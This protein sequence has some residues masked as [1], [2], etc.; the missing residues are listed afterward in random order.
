MDDAQVNNGSAYNMRN[1]SGCP[2]VFE[3]RTLDIS[4]EIELAYESIFLDLFCLQE[5]HTT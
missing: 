4:A 3:Q 5:R 2:V 1:F